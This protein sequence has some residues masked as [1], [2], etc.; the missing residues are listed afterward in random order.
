[1]ELAVEILDLSGQD[2]AAVV[3][4]PE[5]EFPD[6]ALAGELGAVVADEVVEARFPCGGEEVLA[7]RDGQRHGAKGRG[8]PEGRQLIAHGKWVLGGWA[9]G[10]WRSTAIR[11]RHSLG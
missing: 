6:A 3:G 5:V 1:M 8:L 7:D 9:G 11:L 2:A 4:L 10:G